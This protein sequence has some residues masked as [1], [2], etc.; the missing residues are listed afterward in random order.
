MRNQ[1]V[2]A[3]VEHAL[4]AGITDYT[5]IANMAWYRQIA[6]FGWKCRALGPSRDFNGESLI[7]LHIQIDAQ[8]REKLAAN[9][10]YC[11]STFR[12]ANAGALQ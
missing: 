11:R 8:T 12:V 6:A 7:A 5:A 1:L 10:I 3:L 2:T 9:S 4:Q